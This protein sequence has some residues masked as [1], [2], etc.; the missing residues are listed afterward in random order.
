[1]KTI[2][3][4]FLL[5]VQYPV[6]LAQINIDLK[7]DV[8]L[9]SVPHGTVTGLPSPSPFSQIIKFRTYPFSQSLDLKVYLEE[10]AQGKKVSDPLEIVYW[11]RG[12]K[13]DVFFCELIPDL[14]NMQHLHLFLN[15]PRIM[16]HREKQTEFPKY[17]RYSIYQKAKEESIDTP[18]PL[19]LIYEDD[20]KTEKNKKIVESYLVNDSLEIVK[21]KELLPKI[22]RYFLVHYQ[23]SKITDK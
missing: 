2:I 13:G 6:L 19:I 7:K 22:E 16:G 9:I 5:I 11:G 12:S 14:I 1:M 3:L 17:F 21:N 4:I 8:K 23:L 15:T 10:Y 18:V 20:I